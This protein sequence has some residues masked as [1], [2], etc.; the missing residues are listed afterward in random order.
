MLNSFK[1]SLILNQVTLENL[2]K[3]VN[4]V[5]GVLLLG[6]G[7]DLLVPEIR[8]ERSQIQIK[9]I[10]NDLI[11]L[12]NK[13]SIA[14]STQII[15]IEKMSLIRQYDQLLPQATGLLVVCDKALELAYLHKDN[16]LS[17]EKVHA[18]SN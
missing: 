18:K 13:I 8:L 12:K 4:T 10:V 11:E 2:S 7:S 16:K 17:E 5:Y 6:R 14:D 15:F 9:R 3:D 1:R